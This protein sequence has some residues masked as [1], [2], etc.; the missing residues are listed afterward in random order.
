MFY[1][2]LS[3]EDLFVLDYLKRHIDW[4]VKRK[5]KRSE[6]GHFIYVNIY[7][8]GMDADAYARRRLCHIEG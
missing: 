2:F 3:S 1:L 5:K 6:K 7:K 4:R 8:E